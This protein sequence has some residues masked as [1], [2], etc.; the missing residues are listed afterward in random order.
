MYLNRMPNIVILAALLHRM[1][2]S[3]KGD[4]S[5]KYLQYFANR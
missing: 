4:N 5:F 3:E 1:S 2:K